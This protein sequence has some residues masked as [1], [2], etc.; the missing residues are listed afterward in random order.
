[1]SSGAPRLRIAGQG[2]FLINV[3]KNT[4]RMTIIGVFF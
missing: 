4:D 2:P 3:R 1:M